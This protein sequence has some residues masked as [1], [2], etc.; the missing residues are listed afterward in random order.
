M[1][2]GSG[3]ARR[4]SVDK[5]CAL[6]VN[7]RATNTAACNSGRTIDIGPTDHTRTHARTHAQRN[8]PPVLSPSTIRRAGRVLANKRPTWCRV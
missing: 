5:I 8:P 6:V 7:S 3:S 2:H 4:G 1:A